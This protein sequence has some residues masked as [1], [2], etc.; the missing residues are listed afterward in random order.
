MNLAPKRINIM[1]THRRALLLS[2]IVLP[3]AAGLSVRSHFP[4]HPDAPPTVSIRVSEGT[5][6]SLDVSRDG[7][8][9]VFDLLGQLWLV[10]GAGGPARA[11]TDAVADTAEDQDPSLSPDG[12]RVVFTAERRGRRGLWL[13]ELGA[14]KPIQLYQLPDPESFAAEAAWSPDGKRIAFARSLVDSAG[15]RPAFRIALL[16]VSTR[17][18][19]DLR[20]EGVGDARL[21]APAWSADGRR[22]AFVASGRGSRLWMVDA[23]GGPATPLGPAGPPIFAPALASDGRV[24][25]LAPDS[26][27]ALQVWVRSA[28]ADSTARRL[29]NHDDVALTRVRWSADG[30]W[31]YYAADGKVRKISGDGG[32]PAEI[33]F[34]ARLAVTRPRLSLPPVRFP[35][36][37]A[38]QPARGFMGLA[39]SP[40]ARQ[41]GV[42]ALGKI[43]IVPVGGQARAVVDVPHT[44]RHLT[45]S[46]DGAEVAWSAGTMEERDLFATDLASGATRRVTS[47]RGMEMYP[48]YSP[49]GRWLAFTHMDSTI[50]LRVRG[51]TRRHG[52]G[53]RGRAG[54]RADRRRM[55]PVRRRRAAVEPRL[56]CAAPL[57]RN[58]GRRRRRR[59]AG[60]A[61]WPAGTRPPAE[62]AELLPVDAERTRLGPARPAL[63]RPV[64]PG[65]PRGRA[66]PSL[67]TPRRCTPR[68][69]PTEPCSTSPRTAS[70]SARRRA[71]NSG[72][73]GRWGTRPRFPS[74]CSSGAYGSSMAPAPPR[75]RPKT[76]WSSAAASRVSGRRG[77]C[78]LTGGEWWTRAGGSRCRVS[79]IS[80]RTPTSPSC[81]PASSTSA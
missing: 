51:R 52:D 49:D 60:A 44:A 47:L 56:R 18:L 54:P 13:L 76:C 3:L 46:P 79:W 27:G 65:R 31:L 74:H 34:T 1:T 14:Q 30:R 10:P 41:I 19:H 32:A 36:P 22:I 57:A 15:G 58:G 45:W 81:S 28:G 29:T 66:N 68:R 40:D 33:P 6:L 55:E 11:I 4:D 78:L 42:I 35:E 62:C 2:T 16:D 77:A 71:R 26:A 53:Y 23:T 80:T 25:Y 70:A 39:L 73:A 7:R 50:R 9:I 37:G 20:I 48:A 64:R 5:S 67:E 61:R 17:E 69:L 72:S 38:A 21:R 59:R 43:W 8:T 12:R 75:Q 24:A 63:D